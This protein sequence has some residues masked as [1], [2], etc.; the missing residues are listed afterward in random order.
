[1][2]L[3]TPQGPLTPMPSAPVLEPL[4]L[5]WGLLLTSEQFELVCQANPDAVLEPD[6][7][8][9]LIAMTPNCIESGAR[10]S[11]LRLLLATA[12]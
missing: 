8:G 9:Q 5:S 10:N 4:A 1:M 12:G 11:A 3:T 7:D 2:T 6:G